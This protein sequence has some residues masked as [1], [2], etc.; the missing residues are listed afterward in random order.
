MSSAEAAVLRNSIGPQETVISSKPSPQPRVLSGPGDILFTYD[1]ES[2]TQD[3]HTLGVEFDGTY[4]YVTGAGAGSSHQV[5]FFKEDGSYVSSVSQ[6]STG[7]WGWEDLAFDG[8]YMYA[9]CGPN[10]DVWSVTGLPNRPELHMQRSFP[11]PLTMN[12]GLAF[13]PVSGHLWTANFSS[14]LYEIDE[15]GSIIHIYNNNRTIFGLAWD[16]YSIDGPWLW[17]YSIDGTPPLL[18]SQFDPRTGNYTSVHYQGT[19]EGNPACAAG[20]LCFKTTG[21]TAVLVGLTQGYP[22]VIFGLDISIPSTLQIGAISGSVGI[23]AEIDNIQQSDIT[24][25]CYSVVFDGR[26]VKTPRNGYV[27]GSIESISG[28]DG[29]R[30]SIPVRG[31]GKV[32]ITVTANAPG[33]S[34]TSK[35]VPAFLL[36]PFVFIR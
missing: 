2:P 12:R 27:N 4:Y 34:P 19:F 5:H 20:G 16:S 24:N 29:Q 31:F 18:I 7:Y 35:T 30:I 13:D 6:Q 23:T 17:V 22:N 10:I 36:G 1:V 15:N 3:L 8:T 21:A 26:F 25:V 14:S 32:L 9:S 33:V 11:G 28:G